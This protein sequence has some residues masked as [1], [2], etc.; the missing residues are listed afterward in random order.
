MDS[1]Q[2][3]VLGADGEVVRSVLAWPA[4]AA[5]NP[6]MDLLYAEVRKAGIEVLDFMPRLG[7]LPQVDVVH[8][9]WPEQ[10]CWRGRSRLGLVMDAGRVVRGLR[11]LKAGGAKI[12]L[13]AH[14]VRPHNLNR[15][16]RAPIPG[17]ARI[18]RDGHSGITQVA[19]Q[20]GELEVSKRARR[21]N[22]TPW[23]PAGL[24]RQVS[25]ARNEPTG[26]A[27]EVRVSPSSL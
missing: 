14:N 8:V 10:I 25:A 16:G 22:E 9:H 1:L 3:R 17:A 26:A 6:Y 20:Y 2:D 15:R 4:T 11:R 12:A 24:P 5:F 21:R 23:P 27:Q 13:T 18:I 7:R 19:R